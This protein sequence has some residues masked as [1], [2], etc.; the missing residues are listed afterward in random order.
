MIKKYSELY[1]KFRT[2]KLKNRDLINSSLS[3][4][5]DYDIDTESD[6][7]YSSELSSF[8]DPNQMP[9]KARLLNYLKTTKIKHLKA[10]MY[11]K[12]VSITGTV[13]RVSPAKPFVVRMAFECQKCNSTFVI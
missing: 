6:I 7:D 11:D 5:A 1:E 10:I 8:K 2:E 12:Y 9:I 3:S 13:V 4:V